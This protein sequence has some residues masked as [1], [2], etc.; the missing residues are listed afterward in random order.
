MEAQRT[1]GW[2]DAR[3]GMITAS[4]FGDV[5]AKGKG[6]DFGKTAMSYAYEILA[7]E[8]T[9]EEK[10]FTNTAMEWG[11]ENEPDA[12]LAY[13]MKTFDFVQE[14]GFIKY[15]DMVG[16]SPDGLIGEDGGIEIK[17]PYNSTNHIAVMIS[18]ET[19][20]EYVPQVQGSMLITGRKWWDF[21]S[22]DPRFPKDKRLII[23]KNK[24]DEEYIKILKERLEKFKIF[25]E[26]IRQKCMK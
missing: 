19:P 9:G 21:V 20:T 15:D 22:Y 24:R 3:K 18:K 14:V 13:Q 2:H 26:E 25:L 6:T 5:L 11:I 7:V 4:R 16:G 12:R 23:I 10:G 8:I 1:D 17:C